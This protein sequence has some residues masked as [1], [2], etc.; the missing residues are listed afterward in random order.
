MCGIY[1]IT[2]EN[3]KI[4]REIINKCSHRGPNG[5]GIYSS[6]KVTLGHNLLS[7]TSKPDD[8]K[9]PWKSIKENILIYN[10]E[11]FNYD[12]LLLK[13]KD[14]FYPKSTCDTELLSWLLD[15]F[16][17]ETVVQDIIDSMHS[18]VF[19]NKKQNEIVLS[20]DHVGI[21]PLFFSNI[22]EGIIFSSEIKGLI[23]F[24]NNSNKIDRCHLHA[25]VCWG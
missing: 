10:G 4:I 16:S 21:K 8:G 11:I 12:E 3:P 2:E 15:E 24:V 1:G 5:S 18:F 7:I 6:E 9:Q 22:K 14:K 23:K 13:F 25:L 20:R 17:Y 19:Y